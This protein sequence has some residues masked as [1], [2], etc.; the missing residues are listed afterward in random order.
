M[1]FILAVIVLCGFSF[2]TLIGCESTTQEKPVTAQENGSDTADAQKAPQPK[3]V[4]TPL[5]KELKTT[6]KSETKQASPSPK[7]PTEVTP[8]N[9]RAAKLDELVK[10]ME[11]ENRLK[12]PAKVA[13]KPEKVSP[14]EVRNGSQLIVLNPVYAFGDVKPGAK[15]QGEFTLKN[16]GKEAITIKRAKGSCGCTVINK[17]NNKV[18]K[19]GEILPLKFV[20]NSKNTAGKVKK[21][22]FVETV[23]PATPSK[24]TMSFTANVIEYVSLS[25]KM[26][27]FIV[28][29][30]EKVVTLDLTGVG[31]EPFSITGV[32]AHKNA[33]KATFDK[34]AKNK[35]TIRFKSN[36]D[37]LR[38]SNRGMVTI[39]L[40]HPKQKN[41][42]LNYLGELP[43]K[44]IPKSK[45]FRK[46]TVDKKEQ[47]TIKVTS[48][49]GTPFELGAIS[50]QNGFIENITAKKS[51]KGHEITF[52]FAVPAD[53][54][55]GMVVDY[56][57]IDIKNKPGDK[58]KVY[59]YTRLR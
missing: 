43:F 33:V 19:P 14:K 57:L 32:K 3:K 23:S 20:Y 46:V 50:S 45:Y 51:A 39:S 8:P 48:N 15:N 44:A 13:A 56:L 21:N 16:N 47:A 4:A 5:K 28:G 52:D 31:D 6:Q 58:L 9:D 22:V 53:Q 25:T 38:K 10:E 49:N 24:L 54:K 35:H 11:K 30:D 2:I 18:L 34:G 36:S 1:K 41:L 12:K 42:T 29:S 7:K 37:I 17:Y 26:L 27:T 59:C 55:K 40:D